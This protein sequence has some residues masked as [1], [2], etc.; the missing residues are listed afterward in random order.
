MRSQEI[1]VPLRRRRFAFESRS[2]NGLGTEA[3]SADQISSSLELY[4]YCSAVYREYLCRCLFGDVRESAAIIEVELFAR[5]ASRECT[6][7]Q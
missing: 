5:V 7:M 3:V 2:T 4:H 6:R 1:E